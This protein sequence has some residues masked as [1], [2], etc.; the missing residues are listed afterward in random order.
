MV[1]VNKSY[2]TTAVKRAASG[3]LR[4]HSTQSNRA[5]VVYGFSNHALNK[6]GVEFKAAWNSAASLLRRNKG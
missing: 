3:M 2:Q 4:S 6:T 5:S 1:K